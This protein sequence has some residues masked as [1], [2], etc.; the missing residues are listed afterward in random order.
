M[1]TT[2]AEAWL[3]ELHIPSYLLFST[4]HPQR[5][6]SS[7]FKYGNLVS[8]PFCLQ[9]N[10]NTGKCVFF[11]VTLLIW[12]KTVME[13][14]AIKSLC[15]G[16]VMDCSLSQI[17]RARED[18]RKKKLYVL[19]IQTSGDLFIEITVLLINLL[20]SGSLHKSFPLLCSFFV[21]TVGSRIFPC[22]ALHYVPVYS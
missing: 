1:G 12:E 17:F 6:L 21:I 16:A 10:G 22:C 18:Q 15:P 20:F 19:E 7:C 5:A 14:G 11:K 13:L 9:E 3:I 4:S 8:F 2:S